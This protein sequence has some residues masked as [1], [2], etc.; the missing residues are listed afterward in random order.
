MFYE[1]KQNPLNMQKQYCNNIVILLCR[2][3]CKDSKNL[4]AQDSDFAGTIDTNQLGLKCLYP[5]NAMYKFE[6]KLI[7]QTILC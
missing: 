4:G 7:T 5:R 1:F 6:Q 3:L 2:S